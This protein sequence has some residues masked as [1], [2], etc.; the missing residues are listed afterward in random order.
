MFQRYSTAD[1]AGRGPD[2]PE[3]L[4]LRSVLATG[5]QTPKHTWDELRRL[6]PKVPRRAFS[7]GQLDGLVVRLSN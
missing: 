6:D 7:K 3:W 2:R 1:A 5:A 4:G